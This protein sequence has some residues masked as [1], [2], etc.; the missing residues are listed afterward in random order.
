MSSSF[1]SPSRRN[2]RLKIDVIVADA[3]LSL[4]L[5]LPAMICYIAQ[6]SPEV[7]EVIF[8]HTKEACEG[9]E[10]LTHLLR[11]CKAWKVRRP[12]QRAR[13]VYSPWLRM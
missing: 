12:S 2:R 9:K 7:L 5:A 8:E 6:L 3:T 10:N 4:P 11:V 13:Q 1:V